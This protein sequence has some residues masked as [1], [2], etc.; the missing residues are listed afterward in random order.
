MRKLYQVT[1]KVFVIAI[2][3]TSVQALAQSTRITGMVTSGDDG[4]ALPGVSIV[5]KGTTN[6]TV[7]DAEGRYSLNAS[8]N[9]ILVFSF[10]GFQSQEISVAGKSAIDVALSSDVT[11]LTEIVVVGY[12]QQEKKDVTG[13]V[14]AVNEET[15]NKGAIVS[16]D[17]LIT[18]KIAGVQITSNSGEPGG[19][20]SIRIR[21]GTSLNASNEPLYVIDGVPVDNSAFNPGGFS[22]GR[23]PLNFINPNDI[24]TF[25]VLKD[26]SA[27]AI[28]GSRAANGVIIITTKKGK[29][30][31]PTVSYDG[32]F[33][34]GKIADR[35]DV[36]TADQFREVIA[37]KAPQHISKLGTANTDWQDEI[38]QDATGQNHNIT[39]SG[40]TE[41]T[42][43]RA[44]VSHQKQE[45]IIKTSAVE[46]TAFS[47]GLTQKMLDDDLSVIANVKGARILD[48]FSP[49]VVG[50]A[51]EMDPTQPI[52]DATSPWGGY[53][54]WK[55]E[56][57][58]YERQATIN[59]VSTLNQV[60]ER[61]VSNRSIGNI[62]FDY[63]IRPVKGLSAN[64][65]LGYDLATG[66]R[67]RFQPSN[68][69]A[70]ASDTG[71]I[72][73]ENYT[74]V[75]Q[76]LES[77]LNYKRKLENI[78]ST[79]DVTVGYSWQ[80]W[81]SKYPSLRATRLTDNGYGVSNP[82]V[83]KKV[84]AFNSVLENRL[85]SFFGRV[86]YSYK[87]KYL[88]T[89]SLRRD[90]STR[91]G[92]ANRWGTF[93]SAAFAWRVIDE[94]F[95]ESL[96]DIF[97]DLK[98]K[99]GYGVNGNQEIPDYNYL[100]T[101]SPSTLTAQYQL[102]NTFITTVRPNG[103]DANLKWEETTS[104]NIG[105]EYGF[106]NGRLTGSLDFYRKDT[107]DLL[108]ER[109]V[110]SGS[111]LTN[112]ILSNIG[113]IK[114]TGVELTI[115]AVAVSKNDLTWNISFN[116]SYN[117][118]EIVALDGSD[119]PNFK[120][121]ETGGISGGVGNNIQILKVG[122]PAYSFFV[123]K[124]KYGADGKP[125]VNGVDYNEDGK[126]DLADMY[127]DVSGDGAVNDQDRRPLQ[128]RAP[129]V[130][131]GL[132]SQVNYKKFDLSFTLRSSL[133]NYVYNNVASNTANFIRA[134]DNFVPR[135]M[136]TSVLETNFTA[137]QYFS[138]YYVEKA[139]F[140][141]MDNLSLGYT[142]T[143]LFD[144]S[145]KF[146][147]YGTVQNLF[148]ITDYSGLDPEVFSGIDNNLYPRSRTFI[149]GV[150]VTF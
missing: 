86:N 113:E 21:G 69:F 24:E 101:Y 148:V 39:F 142:A 50:A 30:G 138:D 17:Q 20:S 1:L 32:W 96:T 110:P 132:T 118:N 16:P 125:L 130:M 18:G 79:F 122:Q 102:G 121:Y 111:N 97:T 38:Y 9:A 107:K 116:T 48:R 127:E 5:E 63:K 150:N 68:Y 44:S 108:F 59:P 149:V 72:K 104:Y 33:S 78:N 31:L 40:G 136:L 11:A 89:A 19:Q 137:P 95:M 36:F 70:V 4:T 77:F 141:R 100:A 117:K 92:P 106:L 56:A 22:Q 98:L 10:V 73:I 26:A 139:S 94:S 103:Y 46:R 76:L 88:L 145:A 13:V 82:S 114:N 34:V 81:N 60:E 147:L 144:T 91:F 62:Q 55:N 134:N 47:M 2:L 57:G 115:D 52:Y 43:Y 67:D 15:F 146:R 25:T 45:G 28:Y 54:V 109:A 131:F 90:G 66:D 112:I 3:F 6:G 93:Q 42:T 71:E 135:N 143:N 123:Y 7:T 74:R 75:S 80:D 49:Q 23:N 8:G 14:A 126:A 128:Q 41:K 12:G 140:L 65:N 124:Q 35:L 83:A 119:E 37:A 87:D 61:G 58:D 120:G 64:V 133:G 99:V 85:I 51:M 27:A 53:F 129:K 84:E 29:S 105:L